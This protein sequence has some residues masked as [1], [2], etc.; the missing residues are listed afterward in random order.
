MPLQIC[1]SLV[2]IYLLL[3]S[4]FFPRR[5]NVGTQHGILLPAPARSV[6]SVRLTMRRMVNPKKPRRGDLV[7][8]TFTRH[9]LLDW[10]ALKG[11]YSRSNPR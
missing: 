4:S 9:Y 7:M 3:L 6:A 8:A 11:M 10:M 1:P 2:E 5:T